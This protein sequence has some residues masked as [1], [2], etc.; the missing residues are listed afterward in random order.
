MGARIKRY[1]AHGHGDESTILATIF[2]VL[3]K[4]ILLD[5]F[6]HIVFRVH[7]HDK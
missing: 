5:K 6:A 1:F 2:S 4:I 3:Y 7:T